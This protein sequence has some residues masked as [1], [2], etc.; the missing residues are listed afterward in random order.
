MR[1]VPWLMVVAAALVALLAALATLQYRWLGNVS[2]AER[3]RMRAGLRTRVSDFGEAFDRELTRIYVAF[4]VD[5]KALIADPAH[6]IADAFAAW[7]STAAAPALVD[8]VYLLEA[9]SAPALSLKRLDPARSALDP[10]D[11]PTPLRQWR[12]RAD[13][14]PSALPGAPPLFMPDA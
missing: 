5:A 1:R 3:E 12:D 4:H 14:P 6:T 7:Q 11:W 8:A 10:V 2:Q 9:G 13:R